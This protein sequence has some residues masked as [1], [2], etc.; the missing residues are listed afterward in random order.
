MDLVS[1][2]TPYRSA[3]RALPPGP[4]GTSLAHRAPLPRCRR[5]PPKRPSQAEECSPDLSLAKRIGQRSYVGV[6]RAGWWLVALCVVMS[7]RA[8][9]IMV[10]TRTWSTVG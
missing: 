5:I 8:I 7:L 10:F 6:S 2:P 9:T 3:P 4:A 1:M